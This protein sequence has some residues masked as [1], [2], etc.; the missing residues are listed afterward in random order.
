MAGLE[1]TEKVQKPQS[2]DYLLLVGG[3]SWVWEYCEG[4]R[5]NRQYHESTANWRILEPTRKEQ[6]PQSTVYPLLLG[7]NS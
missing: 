5:F 7:R 3:N 4:H 6:K 1:P 2:T